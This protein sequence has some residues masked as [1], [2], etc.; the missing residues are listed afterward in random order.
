MQSFPNPMGTI[1]EFQSDG[2]VYGVVVES[3]NEGGEDVVSSLW[4]DKFL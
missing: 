2:N 1:T 4:T 3:D